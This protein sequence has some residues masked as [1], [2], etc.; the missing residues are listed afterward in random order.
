M[1]P[2]WETWLL[3]QSPYSLGFPG[4]SDGKE[5][6]CNAVD[7]GLIPG[8]GRFPWTRKWQPTPVVLPGKSHGWRSLV[9]SLLICS[10]F[11]SPWFGLGRLCVPRDLFISSRVSGWLTCNYLK[12]SYSPS[13]FCDIS[14]NFSS[15]ISDFIYLSPLSFSLGESS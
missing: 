2:F 5:P 10:D 14:C 7:P 3:I 11:V 9:G 8:S 4:G 13:Y 12:Y 1:L 6:V 15:F